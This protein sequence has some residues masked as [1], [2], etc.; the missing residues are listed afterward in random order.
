MKRVAPSSHLKE[1]VARSLTLGP[2]PEESDP[3]G[4]MIRLAARLVLQQALEAEQ[5]EYLGVTA[6]GR[7]VVEKKRSPFIGVSASTGMSPRARARPRSCFWYR[8]RRSVDP[9][10]CTVLVRWPSWART[11]TCRGLRRWRCTRG[12]P[13]TR[14]VEEAFRDATGQPILSRSAVSQVTEALWEEHQAFEDRDLSSL[15]I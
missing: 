10:S 5:A 9:R 11:R 3:A 12:G 8:R 7:L 6:A 15:S 13:S 14:D 4:E 2:M 1:G